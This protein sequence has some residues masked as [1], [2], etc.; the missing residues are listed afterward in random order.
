MLV[1]PASDGEDQ[2]APIT[3]SNAPISQFDLQASIMK[4]MTGD[5]SKYGT[6]FDEVAEG[7]SRTRYYVH[8]THD[9]TDDYEFIEYEIDGYVL[10]FDN[11]HATGMVW[12]CFE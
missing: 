10:D 3:F 5:G 6:A 9:G 11:W 12:S 2:S 7:E 1:K 4:A 8:P